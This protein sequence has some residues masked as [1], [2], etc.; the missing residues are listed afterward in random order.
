MDPDSDHDVADHD[1]LAIAI[2][3]NEAV[4]LKEIRAAL[5]SHTVFKS[6]M[7]SCN[8]LHEDNSDAATVDDHQMR[9]RYAKCT[10]VRCFAEIE[11]EQNLFCGAVYAINTCTV[12]GSSEV[13]LRGKHLAFFE[14]DAL[15]SPAKQ[16]VNSPMKRKIQELM[17]EDPHRT[18]KVLEKHLSRCRR[19]LEFGELEI[20]PMPTLQQI[21]SVVKRFRRDNGQIDTLDA[22][23]T[24]LATLRPAEVWEEQDP[25]DAFIFGVNDRDGAVVVGVGSDERPFR[26]SLTC[27][28]LLTK[29][30]EIVRANPDVHVLCHM[31]TTFKTNRV[32]Y[33]VFV[34]GYSDFAGKFHLL[35]MSICSTR[36]QRDCEYALLSLK[37]IFLEKCDFNFV[38]DFIVGDAD[39]AQINAVSNVFRDSSYLMCF[40]HLLKNVVLTLCCNFN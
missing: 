20:T 28:G 13:L 17:D 3:I 9:R 37:N 16:T 22:V 39:G 8:F 4:T 21:Q 23:L 29:F 33:P 27:K 25:N 32:S 35:S 36:Q 40:F 30:I 2:D 1:W 38:P 7:A 15:S 18:P 12:D 6:Q 19:T 31:D 26:I 11:G 5:P 10:S 34:V 24:K 14:A